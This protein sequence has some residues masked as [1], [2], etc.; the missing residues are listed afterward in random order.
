MNGAFWLRANGLAQF[1]AL[2]AESD[3][4]LNASEKAYIEASVKE[5]NQRAL[6]KQ[7]VKAREKTLEQRSGMVRRGLV[8]V[9]LVAV[10]GAFGLTSV[11][12][13]QSQV[14]DEM[15]AMRAAW[16]WQ[17]RRKAPNFLITPIRLSPWR[18]RLTRP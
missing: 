3:L 14:A 11:A 15:L 1:D 10:I 16:H 7:S 12:V 13:K 18:W 4:A 6:E 5:R 2:L 17:R 8:V 9:L